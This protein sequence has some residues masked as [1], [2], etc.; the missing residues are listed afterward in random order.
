MRFNFLITS[1]SSF[2]IK[3]HNLPGVAINIV[4]A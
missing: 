1:L 3:S 4:G 2:S